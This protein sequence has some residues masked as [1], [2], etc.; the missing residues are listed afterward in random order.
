MMSPSAMAV[1]RGRELRVRVRWVRC[2]EAPRWRRISLRAWRGNGDSGGW[3]GGGVN[4]GK[5]E[6][7]VL[8]VIEGDA[9]ILVI[10]VVEEDDEEGESP[11]WRRLRRRMRALRDGP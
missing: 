2:G 4:G 8:A 7:V 10:A 6:E 1:V 5:E 11:T 3:K 9:E